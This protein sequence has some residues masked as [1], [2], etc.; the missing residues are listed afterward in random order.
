MQIFLCNCEGTMQV[1]AGAIAR[2]IGCQSPPK[3]FTQ[4]CR[5]QLAT[6]E[7]ALTTDSPIMVACTQEAPLF[8]ETAGTHEDRTAPVRFVNVRENAGWASDKADK[9]PKMAALIAAAALE[10]KPTG[11]MTV[12]SEGQCLVYGAGQQA[13]D[14]AEQLAPRLS[15]TVILTSPGDAIPPSLVEVPIHTGHIRSVAGT[16]G[17]FSVAIDRFAAAVPSSKRALAFETPR[18]GFKT[19]CDIILDLS[20]GS[21][22]CDDKVK[23]D[24]YLRVDPGNPVLVGKAAFEAV[25]LVGEFEKPL[26]VAYD[27]TICAHSRSAKIG[28]RNCIDNCPAGAIAPDGDIVAIDPAVCGGCGS[29]SAVCPTG[30]VSYQYPTRNDLIRR[31]QVLASTYCAVGGTNPVLMIHDESHG[32]GAVNMMARFGRGLPANVIPLA[33]YS[34]FQVGHDVFAS[35]FASGFARVV[36][37]APPDRSHDLPALESQAGLMDAVLS[38]LELGAGRVTILTDADPEKIE[39]ALH[40]LPPE[41]VIEAPAFSPVG[42]KREIARSALSALYASASTSCDAIELPAGAPYGRL[43]VDVDN[44]TLCLSCVGA[45][46]AGALTDDAD[47]PRLRFTEQACVQCGLCVTTCPEKVIELEPR[48]NFSKEVLDPITIKE[49]EPFECISCGKAF[50]TRS[51]VEHIIAKLEGHHA[52]FRNKA[53]TDLIRMCDNCRVIALAE[54]GGDPMA[55]G[56]RPRVRTTEDYIMEEATARKP[57]DNDEA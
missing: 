53:Q 49:E 43:A 50:G 13:I 36:V 44:C 9:S 19:T 52:M 37:V 34:V 4:L 38:G 25:D 51:S 39:T 1:D 14:V 48:Y 10:T 41:D 35:A 40:D 30:A 6:F 23:R 12:R 26:Y 5:S 17:R 7:D 20:G 2:N 56:E 57:N 22:L 47:H 45:C 8:S 31:I 27:Q 42:G 32:L 28:C 55:M 54:R 24:G 11:V 3:G 18:D 16:L 15:V 46:P 29:C 33:V 21:A